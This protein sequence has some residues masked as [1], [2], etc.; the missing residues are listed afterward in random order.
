MA[1]WHPRESRADIREA[2]N[3]GVMDVPKDSVVAQDDWAWLIGRPLTPGS[4]IFFRRL[5]TTFAT[6]GVLWLACL[7]KQRPGLT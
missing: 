6:I 2:G 3:D 1:W 4:F 7:V 5:V